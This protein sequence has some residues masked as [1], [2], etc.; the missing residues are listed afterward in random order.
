[1]AFENPNWPRNAP[2][3]PMFG[4]RSIYTGKYWK[5]LK[6]VFRS[7]LD[8]QTPGG[9]PGRDEVRGGG[10]ISQSWTGVVPRSNLAFSSAGPGGGGGGGMGGGGGGRGGRGRGGRRQQRNVMTQR[11]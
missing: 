7:L 3:R 9:L 10:T 4:S 2:G 5:G 11:L 6:G 1:M 8:M